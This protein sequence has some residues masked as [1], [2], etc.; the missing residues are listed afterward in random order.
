METTPANKKYGNIKPTV[1]Y[2]RSGDPC[3]KLDVLKQKLTEINIIH[4]KNITEE[5]A[6]FILK[7]KN[8]I[9]L[10]V[11]ING[12]GA[13]QLEPNIPSVKKMFEMLKYLI[14]KGFR[15]QQLL[16]VIDPILPNDNGLNALRLLLRIFTE[17]KSLRL[18]T[19][20]FRVLQYS[21]FEDS[22]IKLNSNQKQFLR[23]E[24]INKRASTNYIRQYLF[25]SQDFWQKFYRLKDDYRNIIGI[26]SGEGP[27]IGINE[28]VAFGINNDWINSEGKHEKIISY[29]KGNRF[30]PI[31]N[32][33]SGKF[34]VRCSNRCLL[35][36]W[37]Y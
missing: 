35:C 37:K 25:Q 22:K 27:L 20:R 30:K 36:P 18:R 33:I 9:F 31:L 8:R 21:N 32:I 16:V 1:S 2:W 10:H 6:E 17:F 26:D 12:M 11:C 23:N 24:N 13:T 7:N 14:S 34:A 28:L 19:V 4:T 5:F 29:E 15:Q 3:K